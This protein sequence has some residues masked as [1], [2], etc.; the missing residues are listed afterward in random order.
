MNCNDKSK[1][2]FLFC[3][4]RTKEDY[5]RVLSSSKCFYNDFL[6]GALFLCVGAIILSLSTKY[7]LEPNVNKYLI[8]YKGLELEKL[9]IYAKMFI[10]IIMKP[11]FKLIFLGTLGGINIF[12][13]LKFKEAMYK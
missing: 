7:F 13:V 4:V 6:K 3:P 5:K 9:F 1:A 10:D 11:F 8:E 12:I 2:T